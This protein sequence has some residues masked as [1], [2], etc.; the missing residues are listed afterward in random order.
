MPRALALGGPAAAGDAIRKWQMFSP[1]RLAANG[2]AAAAAGMQAGGAGGRPTAI[3]FSRAPSA[4]LPAAAGAADIT[5]MPAAGGPLGS[6]SAAPG[7]AA[8]G[9]GGIC[10]AARMIV[11]KGRRGPHG[12]QGETVLASPQ[13]IGKGGRRGAGAFG[14]GATPVKVVEDAG[15]GGGLGL[16][17]PGAQEAHGQPAGLLSPSLAQPGMARHRQA[18]QVR[19]CAVLGRCCLA[20]VAKWV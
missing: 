6:M 16:Q 13:G 19:C 5:A 12:G 14:L 15:R 18:S 11:G 17:G 4:R 10:G 3:S 9:A 7:G 1:E 2:G 20:A 8:A